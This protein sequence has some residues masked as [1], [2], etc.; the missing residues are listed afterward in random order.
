VTVQGIGET[1]GIAAGQGRICVLERTGKIFCGGQNTFGQLGDGSQEYSALPVEV[2]GLSGAVALTG[3]N[4][5]SCALLEDDALYLDHRCR[6]IRLHPVDLAFNA[7]SGR[8]RGLDMDDEPPCPPEKTASTLSFEREYG[9]ILQPDGA[10]SILLRPATRAASVVTCSFA[11]GPC[12]TLG[13]GV[14]PPKPYKEWNSDGRVLYAASI[15]PYSEFGSDESKFKFPYPGGPTTIDGGVTTLKPVGAPIF[16]VDFWDQLDAVGLVMGNHPDPITAEKLKDFFEDHILSAIAGYLTVERKILFVDVDGVKHSPI[17]G[18]DF[19]VVT[20][21]DF[22]NCLQ[23]LVADPDFQDKL[24]GFIWRDWGNSTVRSCF[25]SLILPADPTAF[26]DA[27]VEEAGQGWAGA[28]CGY[29]PLTFPCIDDPG[30]DYLNEF[31]ETFSLSELHPYKDYNQEYTLVGK[32]M[33]AL[34]YASFWGIGYLL[35]P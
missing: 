29:A 23:H 7:R 25:P 22:L 24:F 34:M 16:F 18:P 13:V 26:F 8:A 17:D 5:F 27:V 20:Q 9:S 31:I 19:S 28:A 12:S 10:R 4:G 32:P 14:T 30:F 6:R 1:V 2:Q 15:L 35:V 11:A 21:A 33:Q 3:G